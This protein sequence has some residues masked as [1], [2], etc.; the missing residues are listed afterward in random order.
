MQ[1]ITTIEESLNQATWCFDEAYS[2][3]TTTQ[4][5]FLEKSFAAQWDPF[6]RLDW[7][8]D[9]DFENPLGYDDRLM[10]I[11]GTPAWLKADD[12]QRAQWRRAYHGFTVS[13]YL[14]GEQEGLL[15]AARLVEV[16]P[17]INGKRLAAMQVAD[18]ARHVTLFE[19]LLREKMEGQLFTLDPGLRHVIHT[20]LTDPRWDMVV[21]TTHVLIEGMGIAAF[22]QLGSFSHHQLVRDLGRAVVTDEARHVAF[23]LDMLTAYYPHLSNQELR[24]RHEFATTALETL[25]SRPI[26]GTV[27]D[28][29][30]SPQVT[31]ALNK[32]LRSKA[33]GLIDRVFE[34]LLARQVA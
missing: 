14:H 34:P 4:N 25:T 30:V 3:G 33:Q 6:T 29:P 15:A 12:G 16:L 31:S 5:T 23:G 11:F 27:W 24:E 9:I 7:T 18:E 19:R 2:P 8:C 22:A 28:V 26:P 20:G 1:A 17:D 32:R 10:P 21:L 13:Q